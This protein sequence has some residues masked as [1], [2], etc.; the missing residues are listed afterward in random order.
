MR[1]CRIRWSCA[2]RAGLQ[3]DHAAP[4]GIFRSNHESIL[5]IL[6]PAHNR[7]QAE[8]VYG[9]AFIQRKIDERRKTKGETESLGRHENT[10]VV[11][12][13]ALNL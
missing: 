5:Q 9:P 6:C 11:S 8:R 13:T 10:R 7:L 1:I 12:A 3:I 2:A 4:F